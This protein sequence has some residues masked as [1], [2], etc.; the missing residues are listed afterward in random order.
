MKSN[1]IIPDTSVIINGELHNLVNQKTNKNLEIIIPIAVLDELQSQAS[2]NK[3]IGITGL[4][5]LKKVREICTKKKIKI[6]FIGDRP[7]LEDIKLARSGRID[8]IIRDVAKNSEGTLITSDFIQSLV[9]EAEGVN[10]KH[11]DLKTDITEEIIEKYFDMDTLSVH[12]KAES[13]PVAKK[14]SPGNIILTKLSKDKLTKEDIEKII[15]EIYYLITKTDDT[16]FEIRKNGAMVIQYKNYRIII[17]KPPFSNKLEITI[18]K[19]IIRRS[20]QDYQMSERL[21][22]RITKNAEGILISGSPGSGKTTL[23]S[24]LASFYLKQ[25]KIIK[26]LESPRDLVVEPEITQYGMLEG[27]FNNSAEILLLVRPDYT[28]FDELRKSRDFHTF[29]DLRLAGIGMIGVIHANESIDAIQRFI[30]K[31]DLGLIPHIIDTVI[32]IKNGEINKVYELKLCVK[33]PSGMIEADLSRPVVE[34]RDFET[35]KLDY[36]I[37][38]YGQE[39]MAVPV[40]EHKKKEVGIDKLAIERITQS[41]KKFDKRP[42][43]DIVGNN[44]ISIKINKKSVPKLIGRNGT[45]I[46]EI[47]NELGVRIDV[48]SKE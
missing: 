7:S 43:I 35:H 5:E 46:K 9:A 29:A 42:I 25:K 38:P 32:F 36:E 40:T 2:K 21:R 27:D 48:N 20:L 33:V 39:N 10:T 26:T 44:K 4:N 19:P 6:E 13:L 37:Y 8:A 3:E 18:V 24:S 47:E 15:D 30:G 31:I 28:I 17:T 34:V 45:R 14:G 23:A 12:L 1:K 22:E 41:I 16:L 11:I